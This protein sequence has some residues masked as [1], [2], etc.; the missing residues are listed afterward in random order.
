M[1]RTINRRN[2]LQKSAFATAGILFLPKLSASK[3][4][5]VVMTVLGP[6]DANAM[7]FTLTHEHVLVDFIGAGKIS[8][9]RYDPEE[10]F[11]IAL[12][13]LKEIKAQGCDTLIECTPAYLGRDPELLK[14]LSVASGL[15]MV[16]NTGYYGAVNEK[17]L[18]AHAHTESAE[19]LSARWIN[20]WKKG[21]E[22]KGIKPGFIKTSVDKTP[23]TPVQ[24]KIISA[25]ALTHLATG[26]VIAIHT[27]NGEAAKEQLAI[28]KS[29]GV[30][31][32]ARIWVHAQNEQDIGYHI[33]AAKLDSW[34]SFD[35]VNPESIR[36]YV[37]FLQAMKKENLLHRV[38]VSQDSGWYHV[39]EPKGGTFNSFTCIFTEFIPALQKEGFIQDDIDLIFKKN[40][41]AAF[42][43]DV[44]KN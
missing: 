44:R 4:K 26:L 43:V 25:A 10:V 9:S 11:H 29:H 33:E 2:F 41:A 23:L 39:G 30:R 32:D 20:E 38:L 31:P 36:A 42:V 6:I 28:L 13:F 12:P 7:G 22:G 17:Y 1:V 8:K 3:D 18:P 15:N 16:S 35:G 34:V 21:I 27:G 37:N 24:Q 14:R 40:P 19:Q 5:K